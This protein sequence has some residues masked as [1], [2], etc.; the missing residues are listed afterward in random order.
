M[1]TA[2]LRRLSIYRRRQIRPNIV[3][4][5]QPNGHVDN[6]RLRVYREPKVRSIQSLHLNLNLT[7]MQMEEPPP[8]SRLCVHVQQCRYH[9]QTRLAASV[10]DLPSTHFAEQSPC[11]V[12]GYS[13]EVVCGP[14]GEACVGHGD[15]AGEVASDAGVHALHVRRRR[16]DLQHGHRVHAPPHAIQESR[17]HEPWYVLRP[18]SAHFVSVPRRHALFCSHVPSVVVA[19]APFAPAKSN[20]NAITSLPLQKLVYFACNM[21]T[22]AVGLWKCRSMGL[23]PTGTGDWLAFETRGPVS[24]PLACS[25]STLNS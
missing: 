22:L 14:Q 1:V 7:L 2:T 19:F 16:A 10:A 24:K 11:G 25:K 13:V 17:W 3:H 23:L 9:R 4:G 15:R 8:T 5:P 6:A 12:F 20:P 21:L 18:A